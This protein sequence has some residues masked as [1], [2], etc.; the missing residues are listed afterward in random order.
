MKNLIL[1][2]LLP[3]ALVGCAS[4]ETDRIPDFPWMSEVGAKSFPS[5]EKVFKVNDYGAVGDA[6]RMNTQAIQQAIDEAEAAGGG[7]VTF[8]PGIYLTGSIFVGNNVN[9]CIPKGTTL[10]G[11]QNIEDYTVDRQVFAWGCS[12][13]AF[14]VHAPQ[15]GRA[16]PDPR[17]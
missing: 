6:V 14:A 9:L 2:L 5:G 12:H 4:S 16:E 1:W 10:I 17:T 3:L 7:T 11:S 8:E 13:M 15:Y